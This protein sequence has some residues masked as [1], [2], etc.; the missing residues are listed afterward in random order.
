MTQLLTLLLAALGYA[1]LSDVPVALY[2][3]NKANNVVID[4]IALDDVDPNSYD[5]ARL[6]YEQYH[7]QIPG[8]VV[9]TFGAD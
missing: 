5:D 7:S 4:S 3:T 1:D 6:L 8:G 2:T 9:D